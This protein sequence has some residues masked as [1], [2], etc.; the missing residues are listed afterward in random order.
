[1]R[2]TFAVALALGV[3]AC[4]ARA[5]AA[6]CKEGK[7]CFLHNRYTKNLCWDVR[8]P[9][10]ATSVLTTMTPT[11][12]G[13][14]G[15]PGPSRMMDG[16]TLN[17]DPQVT[18]S[19]KYIIAYTSYTYAF[20]DRATGQ[21]LVQTGCVPLKGD[22]TD[23]FAPLLLAKDSTGAQNASNI[24]LEAPQTPIACDVNDIDKCPGSCVNEVYDPHAYFERDGSGSGR[25][26]I[27][28]QGRNQMWTDQAAGKCTANGPQPD[29]SR[30][31]IFVA[32]SKTENPNDGFHQY[33]LAR[34]YADLPLFSVNNGRLLLGHYKA[35]K[36]LFVFDA[37]KLAAGASTDPFLGQYGDGDFVDSDKITPVTQYSGDGGA[38]FVLGEHGNDLHVYAFI[39]PTKSPAHKKVTLDAHPGWYMQPVMR[40]GKI[41]MACDSVVDSATSRKAVDVFRVPVSVTSTSPLK[42]DVDKGATHRLSRDNSSLERPGIEV[43]TSDVALVWYTRHGL[44]GDDPEPQTRYNVHYPSD[45]GFDFRDAFTLHTGGAKPPGSLSSFAD[46]DLPG[47][48]SDPDAVAFWISHQYAGSAGEHRQVVAQVKPGCGKETQCGTECVDLKTDHDN[49]GSCDHSCGAN[50]ECKAGACKIDPVDPCEGINFMTDRKN[51]GGCGRVCALDCV[52]GRCCEACHCSDGF[53]SSSVCQVSAACEHICRGREP[54]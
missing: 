17:K 18:A 26:W 53:T 25:W 10:P 39:D 32:V 30:R 9:V 4:A 36:D 49:C 22:F 35:D 11:P 8:K 34:D 54:Y 15:S 2:Q 12:A 1:M 31:Y 45:G 14:D 33:V 27:E 16:L 42:I 19:H 51:C 5:G 13:P 46:I 20:Y 43:E 23:F 47:G 52:R 40:H 28:A 29:A 37:D 6:T 7:H 38:S 41:Y 24:N 44:A 50:A 48:N 3:M 21:P